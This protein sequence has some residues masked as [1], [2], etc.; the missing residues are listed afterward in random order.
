LELMPSLGA[1]EVLLRRGLPLA[2]TLGQMVLEVQRLAGHD[3]DTLVVERSETATHVA[4]DFQDEEVVRRSLH[5]AE[6][7]LMFALTASEDTPEA[8]A[9]AEAG[10]NFDFEERLFD[11]HLI[12]EDKALGPSTAGLVRAAERRG[13]PWLRLNDS[14]LVQ[15]GQGKYQQRIEATT[16]NHTNTISVRIAQDKDLTARLLREVGVPVPRNLLVETEEEA[17]E[18]AEDLG[19]PV[20]TK[21]YDGNHGRGVSINLKTAEEVQEGFQVARDE[22]RRVIVEKFLVGN[23]HRI[24]VINGKIA[25]VA[26]RVP[27]HV[28]GDGQHTIEELI[29]ITN[30]DPR[31]GRGHDKNLTFLELDRQAQ[32]LIEK[33]GY[34]PETVLAVGEMLHLRLTGNLSTGGTSIDRTDA[35][36][37]EN[38]IAAVRAV[39]TVGL[40]IGGVDMIIPDISRPISEVGG[41]IVEVNAA[42]GFRMHQAPSEGKPREVGDAVMAMLFPPNVPTR[43]PLCAITGTNGKTTTTR[44]VAHIMQAAGYSVGLTT[45]DGIYVNGKA[46]LKGDMTGPWSTRVVLREANVDCAVL[47]VARGGII[48]EGLGFEQSDVS[49]VLNVQADH[50]GIGGIH[51]VEEL[52]RVKQVVVQAVKADGYAVLNA[53]D[54][55]TRQMAKHISA[56]PFWFTMQD[57]ALVQQHIAAGGRAALLEGKG[58][59]EALVIYDNGKKHVVTRVTAISATHEGRARFNVANALAAAAVSYCMG[60]AISQISAALQSFEMSFENTPGRM[61]LYKGY[62]FQVMMDYGH[63]AAALRELKAFLD[64]MPIT[65]RKLAVLSAPGDR[66]DDDIRALG[67]IAAQIFDHVVFRDD[68]DLRNRAANE[69]PTLLQEGAARA[70]AQGKAASTE[71]VL[72]WVKA[73]QHTFDLAQAGDFVMV[74]AEKIQATWEMVKAYGKTKAYKKR[75]NDDATQLI[76]KKKATTSAKAVAADKTD[77]KG[78]KKADKAPASAKPKKKPK[79]E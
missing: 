28:I 38:A 31:R 41:G 54:E 40:D 59:S 46:I 68:L 25:A 12:V 19:Y 73:M 29:E 56:K 52:A 5:L 27:G 44:M 66:R 9:I 16:T 78:K 33:A 39:Q 72:D 58:N 10:P 15:L 74:F 70:A 75:F 30:Q 47:E 37:P 45:T 43:I 36:H 67:E 2:E 3:V 14:G 13:I 55:H 6:D 79:G 22:G 35:I 76:P 26:E 57:D 69:A 1:V 18:A 71:I 77:A 20:V 48:R 60:V 11:I 24:L 50:L 64:A 51:T 7:V 23:D 17:V 8:A 32:W 62:P 61:N 34:T 21:P 42:P 53:D 4:V 63:N 49:C 65:G